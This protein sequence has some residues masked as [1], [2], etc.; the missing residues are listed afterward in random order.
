MKK[1]H[2]WEVGS[3]CAQDELLEWAPGGKV[4][5]S[6]EGTWRFPA[7]SEVSLFPQLVLLSD[8]LQVPDTEGSAG[9]SYRCRT[10]QEPSSRQRSGPALTLSLRLC[11]AKGQK[12]MFLSENRR[13]R[14]CHICPPD[15]SRLQP[16]LGWVKIPQVCWLVFSIVV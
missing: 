9:W 15:F 8:G 4:N 14:S 11:A 6:P 1:L 5:L 10:C 13:G 12:S 7:V 2:N 3:S 16:H